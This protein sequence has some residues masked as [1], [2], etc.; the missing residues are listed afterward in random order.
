LTATETLYQTLRLWHHIYGD[1]RGILAIS[2]VRRTQEGAFQTDY[3]EYPEG[4]QQAAERAAELSEDGYDVWHCAH[5]LNSRR[6]VKENA[7]PV[8]ALYADG[9]GAQVPEGLPRPS[10][11]V[12]SSAG[13]DQSYWRLSMPIPPETGES[14]NRRLAYAM[15]ADKS[16]WDLTQLLR[17]PGTKNYKYDDVPVVRLEVLE[18]VAYDAGEL[19]R[20]LPPLPETSN[21]GHHTPVE[22]GPPVELGPKNLKVWRGEKPKAKDTGELDRSGTLLKIGRVLYDAGA[23]RTVI[24]E[25]LRERDATLGYMKYTGRTDADKQYQAIVDVLEREGRTESIPINPNDSGAGKNGRQSPDAIKKR[26]QADRLIDYAL[27]SGAELFVDQVGAPHVLISGE[28]LALN[29]RA[30]NWLRTLMWEEEDISVGGE[31]LKTA[32]GTLA[33]FA[34]KSGKVREL[35]TRAA[36]HQG[37][38]YYQLRPG[39]VVQIDRNGWRFDDTPPVVFRSVPNLKPLPDPETGGTLDT[40]ED[41]I[42]LKSARDKRMCKVYAATIPLPHIPR[43]IGQTTG[44][45]GSGKT[46]AGRVIKRLLDPTAPETVRVDP[47]DFLQKASHS[48]IVM[49]DNV[50]SVPE[51]AVDVL[52]RLVTGE[53]DSKRSLYTDDEDF[54]YEMKRAVLL[55][56]INAPTERGDAQDRTLPVELQRIPDNKRRSEEDLWAQ[57]ERQHSCLLGAIF[58]TLSKTLREKE[59]LRLHRRPRLADWGEYAAAAYKVLGWGVEQFLNDWGEVVRVQNMGTLDGSPV[60]QAILSFMDSRNKWT[61]LASDLY[62]KLEM[63]AEELNINIKREKTWPKSPL[64]LSRRIREVLPLLKAMG[65]ETEITPNG[66]TGTEIIITKIPPDD[67][68]DGGSRNRATTTS[69]TTENPAKES[70]SEGGGSRGSNSGYSGHSLS[71]TKEKEATKTPE[72]EFEKGGE[73]KVHA[74]TTSTTTTAEQPLSADLRPG[75]S[76]TLGELKEWRLTA[77]EAEEVKRLVYQGMSRKHAREAVLRSRAESEGA[78]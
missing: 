78:G 67:G 62:A 68:P 18:D 74:D 8:G 46:T 50:N 3:F 72:T 54:I 38:V 29:T 44:V 49:L 15:G 17:P 48:Y 27:G 70:A 26:N 45:M 7:G 75:E 63:E 60:A 73:R 4:A 24:V 77:E 71:R 52:C 35:H 25:A 53:A 43:P 12:K 56:G 1:E 19:D 20:L 40:L 37:G 13:R 16:G 21:N 22:S 64:W 23:N 61:G 14:L 69:T 36:F 65:I 30:Y 58:D 2:Y 41:L 11:V 47:R 31:A 42:N 55:N 57:F 6:R 5:L 76:A 32:A 28:A 34:A 51:W 9:D 39:R 33:A 10:A 66:K 59:T